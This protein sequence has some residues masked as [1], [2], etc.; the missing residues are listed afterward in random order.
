MCCIAIG[1]CGP[2]V[3][4]H[5]HFRDASCCGLSESRTFNHCCRK[6]HTSSENH[7][8]TSPSLETGS[9]V[10]LLQVRLLTSFLARNMGR[11]LPLYVRRSDGKLETVN[12][13]KRKELNQPTPEQ[14]DMKA[15]ANGTSD[16]YREV[17]MDEAK[18][19]D[20]RRKLGGMLA[21]ELGWSDSGRFI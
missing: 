13:H 1:L 17:P 12:T 21:R 11:F 15:D 6:H 2:C 19:L 7:L 18:H 5:C 8:T 4:R 14:L 3:C 9:G 16:Y 20:W 10:T